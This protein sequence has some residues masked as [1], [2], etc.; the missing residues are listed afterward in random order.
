MEF[1][2]LCLDAS[3]LIQ[4]QIHKR[5]DG[6]AKSVGTLGSPLE[7][8][9]ED[10]VVTAALDHLVTGIVANVVQFVGHEKILGRHLITAKKQALWREE[11]SF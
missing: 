2:G 1:I 6:I 4:C 9:L 5:V 7:P 11:R 3:H 10:I 8:Q